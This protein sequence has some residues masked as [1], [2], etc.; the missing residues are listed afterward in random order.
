MV[1]SQ[2][3]KQAV[4]TVIVV[5]TLEKYKRDVKEMLEIC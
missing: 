5:E 3:G 4:V 1:V 2:A